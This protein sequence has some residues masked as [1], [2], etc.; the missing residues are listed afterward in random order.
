[1]SSIQAFCKFIFVL[2]CTVSTIAA[3]EAFP[4]ENSLTLVN[5]RLFLYASANSTLDA[6]LAF[7]TFK[8]GHF[9]ENTKGKVSLGFTR[10]NIWA[11]LPVNNTNEAT[12]SR[13]IRIDN[14]WL[15]TL[16]VYFFS[17]DALQ[18]KVSLGDNIPFSQRERSTR[19]PS[20]EYEFPAGQSYVLFRFRSQDPMAFPMYIGSEPA[21]QSEFAKNAYL[22][23][24][25]Y[26][27][28]LILLIYNLT[29]YAYVREI[30]YLLYPI[31][32]FAFTAFNFTYTGHG[33]WLVWPDSVAIQ[34]WLMPIL[35]FGYIFSAV[36]FT[37]GFLNTRTFLPA[38]YDSR[39]RIYGALIA[40]AVLL[41]LFG[42]RMVIVLVQLAILS[43]LTFA[44]LFTGYLAYKNK[45]PMAKFFIPAILMGTGGASFSSLATW[46][47]IPFSQAAFRGIEVGMMLEMSLLSISLGFNFKLAQDARKHAESNARLDPLTN[48]YN[49]R[50]FIELVQPSWELGKRN[51]TP[52]SILL[53]DLD[54]FKKINDQFGHATGDEVLERVAKE[55][56]NR[57]R[58][59]DIP[60][61][62]GG[63]E[64]LI[65]LPDTTQEQAKQLAE[66]L[67]KKIEQ[68]A[69]PNGEAV[70]TSIGV[71]SA[72]PTQVELEK[73]ISMAD[74]SLYLAKEEGRN[75]TVV[76]SSVEKL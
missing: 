69:I 37:I 58:D 52:M 39:L 10:K 24:A 50:A 7:E 31:Y 34:Q 14:A 17:N 33:F 66:E 38:L 71:V 44:M 29:L 28:L 20:V 3:T 59:S 36:V 18:K 30:R 26:G 49:R 16:D 12:E 64:F 32:L 19:M 6:E 55:I 21:M 23:G 25:M 43:M 70:T 62:W 72:L 15:D 27:G 13:V 9:A 40:L 11:V 73:L 48:L 63:E 22:Y 46:G 42:S 51:N 74:E 4:H 8:Q 65:F 54:W 60:L 53:M 75:R 56:K 67:R 41:F 45:D 76:H 5:D 1:M 35:M 61:R 2:L 47:V 68:V 57:V